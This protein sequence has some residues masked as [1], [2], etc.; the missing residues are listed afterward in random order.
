MQAYAEAKRR[1][2]TLGLGGAQLLK[3]S[4]LLSERWIPKY[5]QQLGR[6][7]RAEGLH[8]EPWQQPH[9]AA[10]GVFALM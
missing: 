10:G 9:T 7:G 4:P 3:V 8:F 2:K 5:P 6:F 1:P